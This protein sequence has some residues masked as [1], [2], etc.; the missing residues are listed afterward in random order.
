MAPENK[1]KIVTDVSSAE[2]TW[3]TFEKNIVAQKFLVHQ[4]INECSLLDIDD[5]F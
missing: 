3:P 1:N 4:I 5:M 2:K